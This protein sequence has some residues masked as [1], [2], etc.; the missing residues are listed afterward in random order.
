MPRSLGGVQ[1]SVNGSAIPLLYVSDS[2][3]NAVAPLNLS[4]TTAR[5][6]VTFNGADTSDFIAAI[7]ESNPEIF[8]RS[9]G[10]AA[11]VNQDGSINSREH[12]A[13]A[14]SV[15]AIWATGI[16]ATPFDVWQDG[17]IATVPVSLGCCQI[18]AQGGP[19]N[20]LYG[21]VAPGIVAGVAQVNFRAP[22]PFSNS[23]LGTADV[24]LVAGT[25]VSHTVQI[26]ITVTTGA[27]KMAIPTW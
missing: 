8:Q 2:Q 9:D 25:V 5:V 27:E 7:V 12:P 18:L 19:V 17:R 24:S 6:H 23:L 26:Y 22:L 16:G 10:T 1:V 11:A 21:G 13:P 4:G 15:V 14:G 3:V 20:V